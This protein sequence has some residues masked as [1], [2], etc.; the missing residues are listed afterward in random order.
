MAL[1]M[2]L[3]TMSCATS[4]SHDVQSIRDGWPVE[5]SALSWL[6]QQQGDDGHWGEDGN[7]VSLTSLATLA[8]LSRGETPASS[9]YGRC[10]EN[11][12]C[13]LLRDMDEESKQLPEAEAIH[14]WCLAAAYSMTMNPT[15]LD[16]MRV[17]FKKLDF[18]HPTPWHVF[19]AKALADSGAWYSDLGNNALATM[20]STMPYQ[21][22]CT[23]N[24]A[25]HAW[26][27]MCNKELKQASIHLD[28]V[29]RLS[30]AKWRDQEN[31]LLSTLILSTVFLWAGGKDWQD[32]HK[33]FYADVISRQSMEKSLGWWPA[34]AL[35]I[36]PLSLPE[37]ARSDTS[38]YVTSMVLLTFPP[39]RI[40][41]SVIHKEPLEKDLWEDKDEIKIEVGI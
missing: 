33:I 39:D 24:Q 35:S 22:D 28:A 38:V 9:K 3:F 17:Q 20:R 25:T 30:P 8:F 12:L 4:N 15:I 7:S 31:P 19:A 29:R 40:L 27:E 32:W 37:F 21:T 36:D 6:M 1:V 18:A 34:E 2:A 16:S 13:A 5:A 10:V 41:P 26:L 11:A 14:A 23:L